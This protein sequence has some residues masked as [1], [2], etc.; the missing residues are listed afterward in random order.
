MTE[1]LKQKAR[2]FVKEYLQDNLILDEDALVQFA[3]EATKELQEHH[4]KVCEEL[5]N[6]HRNLREK[7][8]EL[9]AQIEKMKCCENCKYYK[10]CVTV[11]ETIGNE[12]EDFYNGCNNS[13]IAPFGKW[14][15]K[16]K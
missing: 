11:N 10:P 9:E 15:I 3:T 5:T 7:I 4:K 1:E 2:D 6:T 14:E 8:A 16:E 12:C 13:V